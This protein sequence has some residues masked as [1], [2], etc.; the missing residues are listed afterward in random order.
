MWSCLCCVYVKVR[1]GWGVCVYVGGG[2]GG[3]LVGQSPVVS[4]LQ[5]PDH[6]Q[7]PETAARRRLQA[8]LAWGV[9]TLEMLFKL[10]V[11]VVVV[12]AWRH[13]RGRT[14]VSWSC[15]ASLF[16]M[17]SPE[18]EWWQ[19][20]WKSWGRSWLLLFIKIMYFIYY[21]YNAQQCKRSNASRGFERTQRIS[22]FSRDSVDS[23]FLLQDDTSLIGVIIIIHNALNIYA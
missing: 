23:G 15:T 9:R 19:K 6:P 5:E 21:I 14:T 11:V 4:A 8:S 20:K 13:T 22:P 18:F 7:S 10:S 17:L 16:Q 2:V 1:R 3:H 12:F